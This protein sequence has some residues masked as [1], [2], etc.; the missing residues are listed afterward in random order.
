[1]AADREPA[2]DAVEVGDDSS[3]L[4]D[5]SSKESPEHPGVLAVSGEHLP[6]FPKTVE[7]D[8][9]AD[10]EA[11]PDYSP[12]DGVLEE[13]NLNNVHQPADEAEVVA[14][15]KVGNDILEESETLPKR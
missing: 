5:N 7:D 4:I 8:E 3:T 11:D 12:V 15:E 13:D 14:C 2:V 6:E 9:D 10:G 1:V